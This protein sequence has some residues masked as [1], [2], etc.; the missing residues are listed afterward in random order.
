MDTNNSLGGTS[1]ATTFTMT[2]PVAAV[3]TSNGQAFVAGQ[4]AGA[5]LSTPANVETTGASA[6]IKL[7]KSFYNTAWT[8]SGAKAIWGMFSFKF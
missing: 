8:N 3:K 7:H 2:A 1:N 4:D 5:L 6:T